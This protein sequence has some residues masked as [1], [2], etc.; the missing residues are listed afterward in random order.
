[1]ESKAK[2]VDVV[3]QNDYKD[4]YGKLRNTISSSRDSYKASLS[5][6][7]EAIEQ[8]EEELRILK[9]RQHKLEGAIEVSE[10]LLTAVLPNNNKTQG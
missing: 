2:V 10:S 9:I 7:K 3:D 6:T 4:L 8:R 1:M 5:Q